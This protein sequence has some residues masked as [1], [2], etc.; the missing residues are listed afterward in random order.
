MGVER[1]KLLCRKTEQAFYKDVS[2]FRSIVR[3]IRAIQQWEKVLIGNRC[4]GLLYH[5]ED[6]TIVSKHVGAV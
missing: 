4:L 3:P 6:D 5:P 2:R 1:H